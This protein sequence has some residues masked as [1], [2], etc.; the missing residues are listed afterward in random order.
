MLTMLK[1]K[2]SDIEML[3]IIYSLW[4]VLAIMEQKNVLSAEKK[5]VI[6]E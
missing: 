5:N 4:N 3:K 6:L 2:K 1:T